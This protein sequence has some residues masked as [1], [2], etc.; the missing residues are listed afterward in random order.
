MQDHIH[1]RHE[2]SDSLKNL[3]YH[4]LFFQCLV[5][6]TKL[7][8]KLLS[9]LEQQQ[10]NILKKIGMLFHHSVK[11]TFRISANPCFA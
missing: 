5:K 3:I 10:R 7:K 6:G 9:K 2:T 8:W 4:S 1:V 11:L